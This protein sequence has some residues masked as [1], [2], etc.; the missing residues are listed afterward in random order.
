[1]LGLFMVLGCLEY[2][3]CD[4]LFKHFFGVGV[5]GCLVLSVGCWAVLKTRYCFRVGVLG[6]WCSAL[7]V[8]LFVHTSRSVSL[9]PFFPSY[10]CLPL[11][12]PHD[13]NQTI[14]AYTDPQSASRAF[15]PLSSDPPRPTP[16]PIP[17]TTLTPTSTHAR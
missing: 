2:W 13:G 1:M 10:F 14:G 16:T 12:T 5:L 7:R 8:V 15:L 6:I 3:G 9:S 4:V 17:T 11:S